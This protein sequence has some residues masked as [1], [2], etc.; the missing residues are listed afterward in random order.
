VAGLGGFFLAARPHGGQELPTTTEWVVATAALAVVVTVG[1]LG[2]LRGPRWWR[3]ASLGAAT[4]VAASFTSVLTKAITS[5]LDHGWS[6]VFSHFEPYAL[7][8][9]GVGTIFLLQSALHAGP[10]TA[11]RTTLITLNPLVSIVFGITMFGDILRGGPLWI[12]V[13][14]AALA[15]LV[16]GVVIL[17]R[18]P[19]VAGAPDGGID[20]EKLGG[21]RKRA[22]GVAPSEA[23]L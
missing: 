2:G 15:V 16:A 20:A 1:V 13:E 3:A 8:V 10:I 4:A 7:G 11:S 22:R 14:V 6:A 19:L 12:T 21:A 5:Y 18:S 17:T 23:I 9:V